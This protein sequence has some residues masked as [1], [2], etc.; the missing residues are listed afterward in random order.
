MLGR[1]AHG[2][3]KEKRGMGEMIEEKENL[4]RELA[5]IE[6]KIRVKE[7]EHA[8]E[9]AKLRKKREEIQKMISEALTTGRDVENI[10][11]DAT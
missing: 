7:R 10:H 3:R 6:S 11:K 8:W 1:K 5:A 9:M 2:G 4:L